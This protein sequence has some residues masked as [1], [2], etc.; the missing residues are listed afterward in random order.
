MSKLASEIHNVSGRARKKKT[1]LPEVFKTPVR[2][3]IIKKAVLAVQSLRIQPQGRDIMA[4][5]RTTAES[6]GTG[7]HLARVTRVKGSRYPRAGRAAFAPG[8]VK[9]RQAH[10]PKAWKKIVKNI[11]KKER[12]LAI[13]SAI[14]ATASKDLVS[15][16]GHAVDKVQ[17]FP[18]VV[19]DTLQNIKTAEEALVFFEKIGVSPDLERVKNGFKVRSGKGALRG[20]RVKYP[21]GPLIVINKDNGASKAFRNF[22][23]V[24]IVKVDELNVEFLAPGSH[25]G[26]LT[27][28]GQSALKKLDNL[29]KCE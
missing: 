8:T 6:L 1:S 20:R 25:P 21:V 14:A 12:L 11:N 3:D 7:H 5:E 15:L 16:R 18:I 29:F 2:P 10:P 26:R 28:W 17:N 23:G 27:I 9:G 24:D 19:S 13:R 22:P 4:G